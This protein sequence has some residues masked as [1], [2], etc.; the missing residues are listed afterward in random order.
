MKKKDVDSEKV[1]SEKIESLTSEQR[2]FLKL[3]WKLADCETEQSASRCYV[4]LILTGISCLEEKAR[5]DHLEL[6]KKYAQ[7]FRMRLSKIS[8]DVVTCK[9][10]LETGNIPTMTTNVRGR[11]IRFF[12]TDHNIVQ[13]SFNHAREE[14]ARLL[15]IT[16]LV[17]LFSHVRSIM[18][19]YGLIPWE[20][21]LTKGETGAEALE[22]YRKRMEQGV[23]T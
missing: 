20:K 22:R 3:E 15:N 21:D 8:I 18:S 7:L 16:Q 13:A 12:A 2:K 14:D 9:T 5:T 23:K 19:R 4:L 11:E 10:G 6:P 1:E 17:P